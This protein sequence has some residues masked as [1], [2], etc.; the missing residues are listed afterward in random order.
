[1]AV[2][3]AQGARRAFEDVKAI[4]IP[5]RKVLVVTAWVMGVV[6]AGFVTTNTYAALWQR[7]L[8]GQWGRMVAAGSPG[9]AVPGSPVAKIVI[10]SLELERVVLEGDDRATLRKAPAHVSGSALPGSLGNAVIRGHRLLWSGPFRE[11]ERLDYGSEIHVQTLAG[12]AVYLVAGVFHVD[13]DRLDTYAETTLP[14]LTLITSDP[15]LRADR[16]VV[17]R[18]VMVEKD[19]QPV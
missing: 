5:W 15:P 19:G 11:I 8:D 13:D 12:T 16:L 14:Y 6:A 18:A 17:V 1:M 2:A 3:G 10:P 4:R 9:E 7:Q